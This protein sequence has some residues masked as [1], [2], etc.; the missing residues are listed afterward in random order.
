M[1]PSLLSLAQSGDFSGCVE[2]AL[3]L[4]VPTFAAQMRASSD[5][6]PGD[7]TSHLL[8][9]AAAQGAPGA[10]A[11]LQRLLASPARE[12]VLVQ[13]NSAQQ[14]AL[15]VALAL[16]AAP[17]TLDV[18][19]L[20]LAH[21]AAGSIFVAGP[22]KDGI[23]CALPQAYRPSSAAVPLPPP[24]PLQHLHQGAL[25]EVD[26]ALAQVVAHMGLQER[27]TAPGAA[28]GAGA[29]A[30]EAA[31][32]AA[33]AAAA[34]AAASA[35]AAAAQAAK[36]KAHVLVLS[37][38]RLCITCGGCSSGSCSEGYD[39]GT[40]TGLCACGGSSTS[41]TACGQCS[42]CCAASP[43]C[44]GA[45]ATASALAVGELVTPS[46]TPGQLQ[47]SY[48]MTSQDIGVVASSGA[49]ASLVVRWITGRA[50]G[51]SLGAQ[52][53]WVTPL[54]PKAPAG[55]GAV[56]PAPL[57]WQRL[58][59]GDMVLLAPGKAG[60]SAGALG[61]ASEGKVGIV[62]ADSGEKEST[63]PFSVLLLGRPAGGVL[64]ALG[65]AAAPAVSKYK[66]AHLRAIAPLPLASSAAAAAP[67]VAA[68]AAAAA[69]AAPSALKSAVSTL[70]LDPRPGARVLRGP[71]WP[72]A[73]YGD[74]GLYPPSSPRSGQESLGT[75]LGADPQGEGWWWRVQWDSGGCY[76]YRWMPHAAALDLR[77]A[78]EGDLERDA[79]AAASAAARSSAQ[80]EEGAQLAAATAAAAA[81]SSSSALLVGGGGGGS[82]E[83]NGL[84][85]QQPSPLHPP[86]FQPGMRVRRGR[87][88]CSGNATCP[89]D[90]L[91]SVLGFSA[92]WV[93][94]QWDS[95]S[96]SSSGSSSGSEVGSFHQYSLEEGLLTL[97]LAAP[98]GPQ[99]AAAAAAAAAS[100]PPTALR[101]G[102]LVALRQGSEVL[103]RGGV[104]G[105]P[106]A[107][108]LAKVSAAIGMVVELLP[109]GQVAVARV[110]PAPEAPLKPT[111]A[112][113][114]AGAAA[115][116]T[117]ASAGGAQEAAAAAA[118]APKHSDTGVFLPAARPLMCEVSGGGGSSAG[119]SPP[120]PPAVTG[121]AAGQ[122]AQMPR[123][124]GGG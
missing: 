119:T 74:Q 122:R 50:A 21:G 59:R 37:R 34:E 124:V 90:T 86:A 118:A 92:P 87:G 79:A 62:M 78:G 12:S 1:E 35:A 104:L 47:S 75:V 45:P 10:L 81:S 2:L 103:V 31:A 20:L 116:G 109:E 51:S 106:K 25:A 66:A 113:A 56:Q 52:A 38:S 63:A 4:A 68:L 11:A 88:W 123:P 58:R 97:E 23:V 89:P 76:N 101:L 17:H 121:P 29:G 15:G 120:P 41:C 93:C 85:A 83:E 110:L 98:L 30:P 71:S 72:Q 19:R 91:G 32:A 27:N 3:R 99:A 16:P 61:R 55:A 105:N 49:S 14:S 94:V 67:A 60:S 70:P 44:S 112:A 7:R 40:G 39:D 95:S 6:A 28:G 114:A 111:S 22:G 9:R 102:D 36:P 80:A 100:P 8:V 115:A 13:R 26:A 48:S 24:T 46:A 69:I 73:V 42:S 117:S 77:M 64:P 33:A 96:S 18:C 57:R 54:L 84:D 82:E 53:S 5:S 65:A 43:A 108:A 107:M